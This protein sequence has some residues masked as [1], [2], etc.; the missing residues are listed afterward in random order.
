MTDFDRHRTERESRQHAAD[1][2]RPTRYS[3]A[4]SRY[5]GATF[6]R[7][8]ARVPTPTRAP[9]PA[10]PAGL[11]VVGVDDSPDSCV[12]LDHAAVEADVHGWN[13]RLVHV[14]HSLGRHQ[15][16]DRGAQLLERMV[17]RVHAHSRTVPAIGR[18]EAGPPAATL[19]HAVKD[20]DLVVVGR[21]HGTAGAAFGMTVGDHV[22]AHHPGP[23][24]VVRVPGWPP[25]PE[26]ARRPVVVGVDDSP[27]AAR[28]KEFAMAEARVRGCE[29]IQ[30]H[31]G[32][33]ATLYDRMQTVEGVTV[34]HQMHRDEPVAALIDASRNAAAV[35]LGR[36]GRSG[37]TGAVL[38]SV[39][40]SV[41]QQAHCPV[42]LIG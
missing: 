31:A 25:G 37:L 24:L 2:G 13:L 15:G 19:L 22:A 26:F 14:Q 36:R 34:H 29:L 20:A 21:R 40:R 18:L 41:I 30:L 3:E 8:T 11:V 33:A 5:L 4:L 27:A 23:V 35:I 28:A 39:S 12:A 9:V 42:F 32:E 38:G 10:R 16:R 1:L 7:E 17:D 6:Y